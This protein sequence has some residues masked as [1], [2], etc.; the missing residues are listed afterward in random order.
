MK[1]IEAQPWRFAFVVAIWVLAMEVQSRKF[2]GGLNFEEKKAKRWENV[3]EMRMR[4]NM[5]EKIKVIIIINDYLNKKMCIID[6][7]MW[8]FCKSDHV[9]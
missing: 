1:E 8:V 5:W 4:D 2:C 7:L 3:W 9:K 6:S